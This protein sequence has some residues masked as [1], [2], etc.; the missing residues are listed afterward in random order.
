MSLLK[1]KVKSFPKNPG[2]Y[3]FKN[4]K[5]EIIYIGKAKNLKN[6]VRSYFNKSNQNK[7]SQI[8]VS[9][10]TQIEYLVVEDEVKALIT[11]ANMIKEYKPKYNILL[12]DDKTFPYIIITNELYPKVKIIRKK[13]LH[14]DGNTYFGPYTDVNYLRSTVKLIHQIF[15]IRTCNHDQS[16]HSK[17]SCFC[18]FCLSKNKIDS[19]EYNNIIKKV[20]LFLKGKNKMVKVFL[21]D[22]MVN[23]SKNMEYELAA[24]YRDQISILESFI[25]NQKRLAHDF[26]DRD[27]VHVSYNNSFG[28]G[29]VMRIR[30]GLLIGRERFN[31]KIVE[32]EFEDVLNNFLIQ[33]Y[34][35]TLEIPSQIIIDKN[36]INQ[37]VIEEWLTSKKGKKV[38]LIKPERGNRRDMLNLCIKNSNFI[39]K[40]REIKN[41]KRNDQVPQTLIELKDSLNMQVIPNRIEAFDNSNI[42]GSN[43]VAGMVCF[44]KGKPVKKEYRKFNIKTVRGIDDFESMREVVFRRYSRQIKEGGP[45]PD[46][47]LIDGGKGQLSAAKESLDQLGL[48]YITIVGLAKKL[49]D[50]FLPNSS[51]PQN[52]SKTSPALYMLRNI[53]DEVHRFAITFHRKKRKES[54]FH[55]V[56]DNI[57]GMGPA[58]IKKI[59]EVYDSVEQVKKDSIDNIYKKTKFPMNIVRLL[60]NIKI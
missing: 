34:N 1:D 59:W 27:I 13:N 5:N 58:R 2:V 55:S 42:Q 57:K 50:V 23:S 7:K 22:L 29:F 17:V 14:K 10:A 44:I 48:N 47:I 49:E 26:Y 24:K 37:K 31:L 19:R 45:L 18:G 30:N 3:F 9:H 51:E 43:P 28:I 52:I 60:K 21:N 56:F 16:R 38:K 35:S 4:S 41:I 25:N 39:L 8:M 46:L 20:I 15:P 12:K 33:Y 11:E 54:S 40:D 36:L 53:R 6:R 32:N